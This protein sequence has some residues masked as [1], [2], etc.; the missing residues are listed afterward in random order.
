MAGAEPEGSR[1]RGGSPM[2]ELALLALDTAQSLGATYADARFITHRRQGLLTED[3]RV[4]SI[5][6]RRDTGFGVRVLAGGAWGFASSSGLS[7]EEVMRVA[8]EA[9]AIARASAT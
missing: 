5:N 2:Q 9:A 6:R 7:R 4:A 1:A 8:A 3:E